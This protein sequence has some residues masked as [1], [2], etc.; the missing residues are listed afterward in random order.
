MCAKSIPMLP[1]ETRGCVGHC[2]FCKKRDM[3]KNFKL[4]EFDYMYKCP[5]C[6]KLIRKI[7]INKEEKLINKPIMEKNRKAFFEKMKNDANFRE[8][9]SFIKIHKE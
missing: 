5:N 3:L 8:M 2:G 1:G 9:Y 7:Y 4:R 6:G